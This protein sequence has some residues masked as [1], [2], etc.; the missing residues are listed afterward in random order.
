MFSA[1]A[2]YMILGIPVVIYLG[3][4]TLILLL[5]TAAISTLNKRK[6]R[7]IPMK[8]H[9]RT[10]YVTIVFALCHGLLIVLSSLGL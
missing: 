3:I 9:S 5:L 2:G 6:I 7:I 4:I 10:A 1:I 8:W